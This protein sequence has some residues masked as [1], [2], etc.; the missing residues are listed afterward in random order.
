MTT[1]RSAQACIVV[2]VVAELSPGSGSSGLVA[3]TEAESEIETPLP[4]TPLS[5]TSVNVATPPLASVA[6]VQEM[7]VSTGAG[8]SHA[9]PDGLSSETKETAGGKKSTIRMSWAA[10]GPE[11]VTTI[12]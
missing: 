4:W 11:F 1:D 6:T 12:V 8:V 9:H 2:V 10:S 5:R 7:L 3:P